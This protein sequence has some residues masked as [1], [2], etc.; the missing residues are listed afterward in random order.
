MERNG[1]LIETNRCRAKFA[2]MGDCL[3]SPVLHCTQTR[4]N[5]LDLRKISKLVGKSEV[6]GRIPKILGKNPRSCPAMVICVVP[7][8][9]SWGVLLVPLWVSGGSATLLP[10]W[11][12]SVAA[13]YLGWLL[14]LGAAGHCICGTGSSCPAFLPLPLAQCTSLW[15]QCRF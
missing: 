15:A 1:W 6:L 9:L 4:D 5:Y 3:L 10:A 2:H 7:L 11:H 12:V 8:V 14:M 13:R